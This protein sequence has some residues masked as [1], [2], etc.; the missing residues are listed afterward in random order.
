[1]RTCAPQ[2]Q[3]FLHLRLNYQANLK[4]VKVYVLGLVL[5]LFALPHA[6]VPCLHLQPLKTVLMSLHLRHLLLLS[7]SL[8]EV[9]N[10]RR[11]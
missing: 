9:G 11:Y 4:S 7:P 1:M 10:S 8:L 2:L 5:G 6:V 3:S